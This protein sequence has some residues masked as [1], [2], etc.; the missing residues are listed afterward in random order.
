MSLRRGFKA[1]ASR[2]SL[3][4]R[5]D[6]RLAPEAP[7][8][9]HAAAAK[10]R[11]AIVPLSE[12]ANEYPIAVKQLT[13]IDPMAWS[14][15][16]LPVGVGKRILLHN[17]AHSPGR[18]SSN[19]AHELAHVLLEHPC[20]LPLDASG[21]RVVDRD[22]E[23]EANWLAGVILIPDAAAVH[24]VRSALTTEETCRL[25]SVSIDLLRMR[26]NLSGAR[27]RVGRSYQ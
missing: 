18:Q 7:I 5:E 9:L 1:E 19:I 23:E 11:V 22:V 3:G 4:L 17:D 6:L 20:T 2:I 13:E 27:K 8:D 15:G 16:L 21:C 25:Y 10:L 26:I 12:F 24:I 14:A